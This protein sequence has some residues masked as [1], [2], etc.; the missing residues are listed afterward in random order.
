[1]LAAIT[2]LIPPAAVSRTAGL[3]TGCFF[4][5]CSVW[6]AER[7][8]IKKKKNQNLYLHMLWGPYR[9]FFRLFYLGSNF[10]IIPTNVF[11]SNWV[12]KKKLS[13]NKHLF[14]P[15]LIITRVSC[16]DAFLLRLDTIFSA[17]GLSVLSL[18]LAPMQK[19][20]RKSSSVTFVAGF[21]PV[22][23]CEN[24]GKPHSSK[25][26]S[27]STVMIHYLWFRSIVQDRNNNYI[28]A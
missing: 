12:L 27:Q 10:K 1:M 16:Q 4:V 24:M 18:M 28:L 19:N 2:Q 15:V 3:L 8:V 13:W 6:Y 22:V 26:V 7:W 23:Y 25:Y 20:D 9:T 5:I 21:S 17:D 11:K 14:S